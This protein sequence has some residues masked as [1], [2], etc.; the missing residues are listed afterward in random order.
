LTKKEKY[1]IATNAIKHLAKPNNHYYKVP[2]ERNLGSCATYFEIYYKAI[3]DSN[4]VI[5]K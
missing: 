5:V 2:K 3:V 1:Q 4:A